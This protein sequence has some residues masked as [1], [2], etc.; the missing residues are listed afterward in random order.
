MPLLRRPSLPTLILASVVVG[1]ATGLFLG[2]YAAGLAVVGSAFIGLL[3]MTV[4]PYIT[5]ALMANIGRLSPREGRDFTLYTAGFLGISITLTLAVI[6]SLPW[7]LPER[8][9]ASFFSTSLLEEAGQIDF[10]D[11]FIPT[12]PFH[13]LANNVVPAVVLFCIAVGVAII[14]LEKKDA[15]L[16]QLDLVTSALARINHYLVKL[17]PIGIFA[18]AASTAGTMELEEFVR[19]RAYVIIYTVATLVLAA[20]VL[21]Y[22]LSNLTP[23]SYREILNAGRTPI[24]TAFVTGKVLIVLPMLVESAEELFK[25]HHPDPEKPVSK[26]RAVAPLIYPFPHAGK[27]LS[28]IFVPFAAWFVGQAIALGDYPPLLSAGFFSLFGSP[29]AAMPFLLDMQKIPVDL[30]QLFLVSGVYTSRL[31]DLLGTV[32]LLFVSLATAC[33]LNG[34]LRLQ[35][36]TILRSLLFTVLICVAAVTGTRIFLARTTDTTYDRDRVIGN[37]HTAVHTS[38]SVTVHKSVP[39][40]T[41]DAAEPALERIART[42]ILR[43]GYHRDNL[44]FSFFNAAGELVGYDPDMAHVLARQLECR[45]EFVPFDFATLADQLERGEFDVAMSGIAMTPPRLATMRFASPH[46][47]ATGA[48]LVR[49]YRRKEFEQRI[50]HRDFQGIRVAVPRAAGLT[51]LIG[52]MLPGAEIVNIREPRDFFDSD[53]AD[54]L[55]YS[56]ETGSAWTLLYPDF[57]V[58]VI[59]P[60]LAVP[61]GYAISRRDEAFAEFLSSWVHYIRGTPLDEHLYDH[62]I[63]GKS[64]GKRGPRWSVIRNVLHWV[65]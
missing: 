63:L 20:G 24:L 28:L 1:I 11:L 21:P 46:F 59:Q 65:E 18:I 19:L 52:A 12:N 48:L 55:V 42:G 33:A 53:P 3:Q 30:L 49:D 60:L 16:D 15:I 54:A 10:L 14:T 22:I 26:A 62:W 17:S 45:L 36:G 38:S 56:A 13:S 23:F 31:G 51:A 2:E 57:S 39:E 4:L 64:A 37:M 35:P 50:Q 8:E 40:P 9:T 6:V 41:D 32:H 5:V 47:E 44:P 58:V 7:C 29:L 43:V 27:L 34:M 25:K 61:V